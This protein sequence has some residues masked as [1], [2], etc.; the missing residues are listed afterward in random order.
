MTAVV[1]RVV[2]DRLA[3][4]VDVID[5]LKSTPCTSSEFNPKG[6]LKGSIAFIRKVNSLRFDEVEVV[7]SY[8]R[9][10]ALYNMDLSQFRSDYK[11]LAMEYKSLTELRSDPFLQFANPAGLSAYGMLCEIAYGQSSRVS[12]PSL[13]MVKPLLPDLTLS[14]FSPSE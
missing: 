5:D 14:T 8:L 13:T 6:E 9:L 12:D 7:D 1:Q 4:I 3:L 2:R 11:K 10:A